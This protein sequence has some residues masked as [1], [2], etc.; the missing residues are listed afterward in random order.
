MNKDSCLSLLEDTPHLFRCCGLRPVCAS[1]SGY[2][3]NPRGRWL[4]PRARFTSSR[5][6]ALLISAYVMWPVTARGLGRLKHECVRIITLHQ[7]SAVSPWRF[8]SFVFSVNASLPSERW[9]QCRVSFH[10]CWMHLCLQR[11]SSRSLPLYIT[12]ACIIRNKHKHTHTLK[13]CLN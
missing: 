7:A 6:W 4:G 13:P 11:Y 5:G 3:F 12:S 9:Q 1:C 10:C 2:L 8:L